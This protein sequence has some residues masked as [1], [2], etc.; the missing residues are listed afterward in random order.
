MRKD[1]IFR[2]T[3][4][5]FTNLGRVYTQLNE[6]QQEDSKENDKEYNRIGKELPTCH[7][8]TELESEFLQSQ[9]Q[10]IITTVKLIEEKLAK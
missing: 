10:N 2:Y 6:E 8:L 5:A 3:N 9:L 7:T 4:S 1:L